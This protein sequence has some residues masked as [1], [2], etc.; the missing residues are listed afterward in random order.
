MRDLPVIYKER[1]RQ[2]DYRK[3]SNKS[4]GCT[5]EVGFILFDFGLY[6]CGLLVG[7][8]I[9][10]GDRLF[11]GLRRE[12][13]LREQRIARERSAL[14]EVLFRFDIGVGERD[15]ASA[16]DERNGECRFQSGFVETRLRG[17][18]LSATNVCSW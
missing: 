8:G 10:V 1:P 16:G 7:G 14:T 11:H 13:V 3:A 15:G 17:Q 6:L 5:F 2:P 18:N 12:K 9:P 4:T